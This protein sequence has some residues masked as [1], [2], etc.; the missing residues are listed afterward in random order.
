MNHKYFTLTFIILLV[1]LGVFFV[2]TIQS[3]VEQNF[4]VILQNDVTPFTQSYF[5]LQPIWKI[6]QNSEEMTVPS[7][8]EV[9]GKE[10]DGSYTIINV[11]NNRY[12]MDVHIMMVFLLT[13]IY[14]TISRVFYSNDAPVQRI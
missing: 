3:Q 10:L 2:P 5:V 8:H 6:G 9:G 13:I 11:T 7:F 14:I 12:L 1:L 4:L